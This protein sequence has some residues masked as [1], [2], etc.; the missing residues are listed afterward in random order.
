MKV[1]LYDIECQYTQTEILNNIH[2]LCRQNI[3][4]SHQYIVYTLAAVTAATD[5]FVCVQFTY[6]DV[7]VLG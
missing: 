4:S 1:I 3:L 2:I 5:C 7:R 6:V